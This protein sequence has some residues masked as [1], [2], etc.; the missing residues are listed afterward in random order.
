MS[1]RGWAF[2][3]AGAGRCG[4][5]AGFGG[6]T[7]VSRAA[8]LAAA[9]AGLTIVPAGACGFATSIGF[10]VVTI[11]ADATTLAAFT[12]ADFFGAAAFVGFTALRAAGFAVPGLAAAFRAG[13]FAAFAFTAGLVFA[14]AKVAFSFSRRAFY[15]A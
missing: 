9:V 5:I 15:H 11:F 3:A 13:A 4:T 8:G 6:S 1:A 14:F 2:A 12:A 10:A 7:S